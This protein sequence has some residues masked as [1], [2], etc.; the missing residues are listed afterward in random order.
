[1]D[2]DIKEDY[3]S[4]EIAKLL[5]EKGFDNPCTSMYSNRN[6]GETWYHYFINGISTKKDEADCWKPT[7]QKAV[8]WLRINFNVWISIQ[9]G[10]DEN[11]IWYNAY[12]EK[13]EKSYDFTSINNDTDLGGDTPQQAYEAALLYVLKE[14]I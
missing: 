5:K 12:L 3:C 7:I 1:M 4:F 8:E 14:V 6:N 10:H 2:N 11:N 9:I 13:V